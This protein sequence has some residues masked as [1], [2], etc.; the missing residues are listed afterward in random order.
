M[1]AIIPVASRSPRRRASWYFVTFLILCCI[2]GALARHVVA[3]NRALTERQCWVGFP[4]TLRQ[5]IPPCSLE[6]CT[7]HAVLAAG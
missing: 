2:L 4:A 5:S 7:Q 6:C 3:V 1:S